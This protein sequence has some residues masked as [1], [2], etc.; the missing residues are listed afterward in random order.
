[1]TVA[2]ETAFDQNRPNARFKETDAFGI[3]GGRQLASSCQQSAQQYEQ[4]SREGS[5]GIRVL[6]APCHGFILINF[7]TSGSVFTD[8]FRV[9]T[10]PHA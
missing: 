5:P 9:R 1:M 6:D 4:L 3:F 8:K 2:F 7:A 10:L